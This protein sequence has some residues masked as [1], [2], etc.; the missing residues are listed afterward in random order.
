[1]RKEVSTSGVHAQTSRPGHLARAPMQTP[2]ENQKGITNICGHAVTSLIGKCPVPA[3]LEAPGSM[4]SCNILHSRTNFELQT[5][6][7]RNTAT[8][9]VAL[10]K[11]S[12]Q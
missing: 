2:C 12:L 10:L 3:L 6:I 5:A 9:L 1:M 7:H 4:L 11:T 8:R